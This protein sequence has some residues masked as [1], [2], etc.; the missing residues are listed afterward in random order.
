MVYQATTFSENESSRCSDDFALKVRKQSKNQLNIA[1]ARRLHLKFF[2]SHYCLQGRGLQG[3]TTS[4]LLLVFFF[5]LRK[6]L[7]SQDDKRIE[8]VTCFIS[9]ENKNYATTVT[10][11]QVR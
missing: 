8:N 11:L 4:S 7:P 5:F 6:K 1:I 2:I 3:I 10:T 9:S